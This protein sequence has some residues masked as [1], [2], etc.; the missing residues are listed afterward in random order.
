MD[1]R[2]LIKLASVVAA[3]PLV[4]NFVVKNPI[5]WTPPPTEIE[6]PT[7]QEIKLFETPSEVLDVFGVTVRA[8]S[9]NL[10]PQYHDVTEPYSISRRVAYTGVVDLEFSGQIV[11]TLDVHEKGMLA[12]QDFDEGDIIEMYFKIRKATA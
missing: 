3:K 11:G 12:L 1:R 9:V 10:R 5:L 8:F 2:S 4:G 6:V 7:E